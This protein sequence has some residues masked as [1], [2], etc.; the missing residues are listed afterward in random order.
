MIGYDDFAKLDIRIGTIENAE[1]VKNS[2]KLMKLQVNFGSQ[3]E[4]DFVGF[5]PLR[6]I[7]AGIAEFYKPEELVGKQCPFLINLEPKKLKGEES[8]GMLMAIDPSEDKKD[9]VIM[10]PDK[11]VNN[12]AKIV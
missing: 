7:I 8:Q 3:L 9:C 2:D 5:N 11:K 6:Q 12:G 10:H 4:T 1:P